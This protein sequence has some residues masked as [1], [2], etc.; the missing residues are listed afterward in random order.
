MDIEAG[1]S[2]TI[3]LS[4]AEATRL[5]DVLFYVRRKKVSEDDLI[6]IKQLRDELDGC[7]HNQASD[8]HIHL[9]GKSSRI[10]KTYPWLI[11]LYSYIGHKLK[12]AQKL[13]LGG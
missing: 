1:K 12:V 5:F 13:I 6:F 10:D 9:P 11:S 3:K 7:Y 8:K 4:Q 2:Y